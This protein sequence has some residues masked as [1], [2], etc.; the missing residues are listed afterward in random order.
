MIRTEPA[1]LV[2]EDGTRYDGL[3][4]GAQGERFGELVFTTGMT[5]YQETLSDPSY[6]GQIVVQT[7]PH[8]GNTGVNS[9]DMESAGY[10]PAGYVVR[11]SSRVVSNWRAE[12]SLDDALIAANIVG[13]SDIDTRALTRRI[14]DRGAMRA[15]IFSGAEAFA[16][17]T[18]LQLERVLEQPEMVGRYLS[19]QVTCR[20]A[21]VAEHTAEERVGS[22]ALLDLGVKTATIRNLNHRGFD[23]HVLPADSTIDQIRETGADAIFY[24]NGPGD[25]EAND[26]QAQMLRELLREGYPFMG[27]CFG[28]QLLGRALGFDTYKLP[29]G[30]RGINQPVRDNATGKVEITAQNHGFAVDVPLDGPVD[31]PAGLGRVEVSH[32]GLNDQVVEGLNCLDLPAFSVQFHPEAASGPHDASPLF[33]RF[34]D[35]VV[36]AKTDQTKN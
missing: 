30:H 28:N 19:D 26:A 17:G 8:I 14:R 3:A 34:R 9:A 4:Y 33:D 2:L 32:V 18:D 7:A 1:V 16:L 23:V 13:I 15:G 35:L 25:P 22:V 24:S 20:E 11:D 21:Y 6:A 10:W 36:A 29:F 31:S 12:G 5:G 27:I